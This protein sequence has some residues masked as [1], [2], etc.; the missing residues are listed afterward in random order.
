MRWRQIAEQPRPCLLSEIRRLK[1]GPRKGLAGEMRPSPAT[2][3]LDRQKKLAVYARE[4]VG[5]A[6][7][8]DPVQRTLEVLRLDRQWVILAVHADQEEVRAVPFD[9]ITLATGRLR[10]D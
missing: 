7:L 5:H 9:A 1:A 3:R 10:V 2:A 8:I 4:G 6:W